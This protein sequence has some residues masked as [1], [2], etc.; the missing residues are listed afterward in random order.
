MNWS[1]IDTTTFAAI[2]LYGILNSLQAEF[3]EEAEC[4]DKPLAWFFPTLGKHADQDK[5]VAVCR[6]CAVR[7]EC[8]EYGYELEDGV[9]G[10]STKGQRKQWKEYGLFADKAWV[11]M[12]T[13]ESELPQQQPSLPPDPADEEESCTPE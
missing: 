11:A 10:G 13:E 1:D 12:T 3:W 9:W 5:G 8:F 6:T 7:R 2:E 4:R